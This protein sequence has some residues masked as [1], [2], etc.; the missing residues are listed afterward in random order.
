MPTSGVRDNCGGLPPPLVDH[1]RNTLFHLAHAGGAV[2]DA[3]SCRVLGRDSNQ[4]SG[5][6]PEH[7]EVATAG[8]VCSQGSK[9]NSICFLVIVFLIFATPP[10]VTGVTGGA[11]SQAPS[12]G[13]PHLS[14]ASEMTTSV[15]PCHL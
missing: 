3:P 7:F 5:H 9:S 2:P 4:V 11:H 8:R 6:C 15:C 14:L 1:A 10:E 13:K 12:G